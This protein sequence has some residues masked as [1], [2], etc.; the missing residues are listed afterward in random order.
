MKS[1]HPLNKLP[2]DLDAAS[3]TFRDYFRS[4]TGLEWDDRIEKFGS[5]GPELFQYQP[6]VRSLSFSISSS[7]SP[8]SSSH[9]SLSR[10]VSSILSSGELQGG[11]K[12]VGLVKER[13][14]PIIGSDAITAAPDQ[15]QQQ[16]A[17]N[18]T[19]AHGEEGPVG[20][21]DDR[22]RA[23]EEHVAGNAADEG[24]TRPAKRSRQE[25][26]GADRAGQEVAVLANPDSKVEDGIR[27]SR[28][29]GNV[30]LRGDEPMRDAK[31]VRET[32]LESENTM[33]GNGK[34][35]DG[36]LQI[37]GCDDGSQSEV[38]FDFDF[39]SELS[40]ALRTTA[41]DVNDSDDGNYH[42]AHAQTESNSAPIRNDDET[43]LEMANMYD[44]AQ[45]AEMV[46]A[47]TM[48]DDDE[49]ETEAEA[50][51]DEDA[52]DDFSPGHTPARSAARAAAANIY[53]E[54]C[55]G[56]SLASD[57]QARLI[58]AVRAARARRCALAERARARGRGIGLE[59]DDDDTDEDS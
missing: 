16:Q 14:A 37:D 3:K 19:Q 41:D 44:E 58:D 46:V 36:P 45:R 35:D 17:D 27:D 33:D 31:G 59:D 53:Y 57:S 42:D 52:D 9:P 43:A 55:R 1:P 38:D 30:H 48:H 4:K 18:N 50:E 54:T 6:P 10:R 34:G 13:C 2:V 12:P 11:G 24:G 39:A 32:D 22:K 49:D 56:V 20:D 26:A 40:N 25:S 28:R 47:A 29:H 8:F 51:E 15:Q 21:I 7:I 23:R 5:T